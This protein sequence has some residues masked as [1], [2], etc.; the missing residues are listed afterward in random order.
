LFG[1]HIHDRRGVRLAFGTRGTLVTIL[2]SGSGCGRRAVIA[3]GLAVASMCAS[4]P[5]S[6]EPSTPPNGG[7][8]AE[9][10]EETPAKPSADAPSGDIVRAE[11]P[12][13]SAPASSPER[14]WYGWQTLACDGLALLT[15]SPSLVVDSTAPAAI[16]YVTF[17]LAAP[18][19]HAAHGRWGRAFGS[20]GIR[21]GLPLVLAVVGHALVAEKDNKTIFGKGP[22][23]E[24]SRR[25]EL[26]GVF[27][28]FA[29]ASALDASLF[30]YESVPSTDE[31]PAR[32]TKAS[33]A[34]H[35]FRPSL[36]SVT[37]SSDGA[38]FT[39]GGIF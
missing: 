12:G 38:Q 15:M 2:C 22:R 25:A 19:V 13:A 9:L 6:A 5:A 30:A 20:A 14:R 1:Q 26:I 24:E 21:L 39:W 4:P 34:N 31:R 23:F 32:R 17:L 33:A 11:A 18:V 29:I 10:S 36:P 3:T 8:E 16:G 7:T 28:G 37:P 27:I 35:S